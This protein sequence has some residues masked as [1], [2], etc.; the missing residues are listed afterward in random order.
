M[1]AP[2]TVSATLPGANM[3][4]IEVSQHL[5]QEPERSTATVYGLPS[6]MFC[7]ALVYFLWKK[8]NFSHSVEEESQAWREG[9]KAEGTNLSLWFLLMWPHSAMVF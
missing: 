5:M 9:G 3:T 8:Q 2:Q 7:L 6:D 1:P 4:I